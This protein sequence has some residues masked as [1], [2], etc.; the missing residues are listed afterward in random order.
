MFDI[1]SQLI[2][3]IFVVVVYLT[4]IVNRIQH[5][6]ARA[7]LHIS[8][9]ALSKAEGSQVCGQHGQRVESLSSKPQQTLQV[10]SLIFRLFGTLSLEW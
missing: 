7:D 8:L 4:L 3:C 5:H 1:Y 9:R 6:K 2:H 10:V